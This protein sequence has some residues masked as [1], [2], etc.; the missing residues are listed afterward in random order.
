MMR[1]RRPIETVTAR[2]AS[3][4]FF[5]GRLTIVDIR[6]DTE[7]ARAR[8]PGATHIPLGQLRRRLSELRSDRPI[9]FLCRSGHRSALAARRAAKRRPDV[10]S[11]DGGMNAWMAANLPTAR[12]RAPYVGRRTG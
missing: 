8:V 2:S 6:S 10:A 9:V 1:F 12:C 7:F 5:T 11:I 4:R 3:D